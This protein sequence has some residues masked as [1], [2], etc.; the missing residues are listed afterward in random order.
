MGLPLPTHK[1]ISRVAALRG[2]SIS[3]TLYT[4]FREELRRQEDP[5]EWALAPTPFVV[6]PTYTEAGCRVQVRHPNLPTLILS[7]R[8][9]SDLAE[10]IHTGA[11]GTNPHFKLKTTEG[12]HNVK[13]MIGGRYVALVV[14]GENAPVIRPAAI[15]LAEALIAASVHAGPLPKGGPI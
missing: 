4:I 13:I 11:D 7:H 12:A 1:L 3:D 5:D 8:E 10:A 15:D 2:Q 9:A 6:K 14:D